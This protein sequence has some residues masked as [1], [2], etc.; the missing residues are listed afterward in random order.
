MRRFVLITRRLIE[1]LPLKAVKLAI[2]FS[3]WA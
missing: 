3:T 2:E 1:R